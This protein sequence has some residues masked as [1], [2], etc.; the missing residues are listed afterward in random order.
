VKNPCDGLL[1]YVAVADAYAAAAEYL[2]PGEEMLWRELYEFKAY[3]RHPRHRLEPGTYTDDTEKTIGC[4][5]VLLQPEPYT[6]LMFADAWVEEFNFGGRRQGYAR[7]YQKLLEECRDGAALMSAVN[8]GSTKNGAAMCAPVFGVIADPGQV[9]EVVSMQAAITHNSPEGLFAAR[10]AALAGHFALHTDQPFNKLESYC[11]EYLPE[12]D[13]KW[14]E[15][16]FGPWSGR[17]IGVNDGRT[18]AIS[19]IH[20]S[21][22]LVTRVP[23]LYE[24]MRCILIMGGDTDTA[25]AISWGIAAPRYWQQEPP[26]DFMIRD[27]EGGSPRTGPARLIRLGSELMKKYA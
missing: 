23:S 5:H 2:K 4:V 15:E 16:V 12:A 25:A 10:I 26:L 17:G 27:L 6:P 24:M 9:L 13:H 1:L 11:R 22:F 21:L 14:L 18:V 7:G 8:G 3:G 19:T 20:A